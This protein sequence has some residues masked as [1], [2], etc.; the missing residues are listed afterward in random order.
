MTITADKVKVFR[1]DNGN[2]PKYSIGISSKDKDGNWVSAYMDIKFKK[3]VEIADRTDIK[4]KNSFFVV[5]EYKGTKYIKIMVTDFE[6]VG[7]QNTGFMDIPDTLEAELP[8][9]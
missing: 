5:E 8:F 3:G 9:V 4:I 6:I 7:E 2:F 1:Y